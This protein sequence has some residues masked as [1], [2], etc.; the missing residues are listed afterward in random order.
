MR[1]FR[2]IFKL[3]VLAGLATIAMGPS[4]MARHVRPSAAQTAYQQL[5][6]SLRQ[7]QRLSLLEVKQSAITQLQNLNFE[8][9]HHLI[10]RSEYAS[11]RA[12]LL[13]NYH[14]AQ[15]QMFSITANETSSLR[16]LSHELQFG[17]I[18]IT[19]F[20][21]QATQV[22]SASH[23]LQLALIAKVQAGLIH[24]ATPFT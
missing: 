20:N 13:S 12:S 19:Q 14:L 2:N 21:T 18:S 4:A 1:T 15:G 5:V 17:Q 9:N 10:S 7:Q 6:R 3:V 11:D 24:P 23:A 8:R 16:V 22:V